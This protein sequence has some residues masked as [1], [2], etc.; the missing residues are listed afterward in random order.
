[1][2]LPRRAADAEIVADDVARIVSEP[3][4]SLAAYD[5]T[6]LRE[7][8]FTV[9]YVGDDATVDMQPELI[10]DYVIETVPI[11]IV[12]PRR[13]PTRRRTSDRFYAADRA[14]RCVTSGQAPNIRLCRSQCASGAVLGCCRRR[15]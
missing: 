11:A 3:S 7:T 10:D 6:R 2:I 8:M 13:R 9:P 15:T 1:V 12:R 4:A 5:P 14:S